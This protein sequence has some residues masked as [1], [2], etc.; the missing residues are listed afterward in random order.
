MTSG[1]G[2][3]EVRRVQTDSPWEETIGF[4]RAVAAGDRVLVSGTMPLRGGVLIGEGDPYEQTRAAFANA[5]DAIGEFGLDASSVIRTRIYLT[6]ARDLDAAARAHREVFG[7]VRPAAT[8]VV[9][10]GFVDSGVLA[11]VEL[12][13][14]RGASDGPSTST[15]PH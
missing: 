10:T 7:E 1:S 4:A 5:L 6:H 15:T 13:A 3:R 9:V 11:E 12:E 2:P 8:V 14:Y